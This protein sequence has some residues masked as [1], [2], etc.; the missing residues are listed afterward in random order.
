MIA[1]CIAFS[2]CNNQN[3]P[4]N[5]ADAKLDSVS[6]QLDKMYALQNRENENKKIVVDFYQSLFGDKDISAIDK[7]I[8]DNYTQHNP[9]VADGKKALKAAVTVWFKGAPKEKINIQHLAAD[10]N[11]VFI[12]TKSMSDDKA[13][14][15]IDIFKLKDGKIIEHW[16]VM[17]QVPAKSANPHPMF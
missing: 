16:D 11:L 5:T 17:Q 4:M 1:M 6:A 9:N 12:H 13:N 3:S 14:S 2:G 10:S 7:Y 8:G 15:V